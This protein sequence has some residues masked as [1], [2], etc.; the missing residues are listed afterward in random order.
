MADP[1]YGHHV[2]EEFSDLERLFLAGEAAE[3]LLAHPGWRVVMSLLDR[4]IETLDGRLDGHKP[5]TLEEYA[6]MH[7][8]RRGLTAARTAAREVVDRCVAERE[9]QSRRH[10]GAGE[11]VPG[12]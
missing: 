12:R 9:A 6:H 8:Q 1:T 2:R 10:E 3:D 4:E 7:G 5:L 11:S